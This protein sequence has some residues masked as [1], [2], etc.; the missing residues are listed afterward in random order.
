MENMRE[1]A[2]GEFDREKERVGVRERGERKDREKT[3]TKRYW[4]NERKIER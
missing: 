2:K 4:E 1:G 3:E